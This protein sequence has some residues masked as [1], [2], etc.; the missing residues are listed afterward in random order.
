MLAQF[1]GLKFGHAAGPENKFARRALDV[2]QHV[3]HLRHLVLLA[4]PVFDLPLAEQTIALGAR[5]GRRNS[6]SR[7]AFNSA[8]RLRILARLLSRSRHPSRVLLI[9]QR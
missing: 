8:M 4:C 7:N 5:G 9:L 6:L 3:N 1:L 2:R